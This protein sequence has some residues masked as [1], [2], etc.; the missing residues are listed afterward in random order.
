[1]GQSKIQ[2]AVY[3]SEVFPIMLDDIDEIGYLWITYKPYI[4][5]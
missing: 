4:F 5:G 3:L 2:Q 1:M